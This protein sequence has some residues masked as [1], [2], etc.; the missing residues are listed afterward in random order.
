MCAPLEDAV[1]YS[2]DDS[3]GVTG[4]AAQ[5]RVLSGI[6]KCLPSIEG[7]GLSLLDRSYIIKQGSPVEP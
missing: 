7:T 5:I 4:V 3:T 1:L 6:L 2:Y